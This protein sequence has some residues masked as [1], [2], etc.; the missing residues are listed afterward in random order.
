MVFI[1][2]SSSFYQTSLATH[3]PWE[4]V[5]L[6]RS[7]P[8]QCCFCLCLALQI[9]REKDLPGS[10]WDSFLRLACLVI[11]VRNHPYQSGLCPM[12]GRSCV[13][14]F[15]ENWTRSLAKDQMN[16]VKPKY[17]GRDARYSSKRFQRYSTWT[18]DTFL[19]QRP[20]SKPPV[21]ATWPG[22][23]AEV[24]AVGLAG[25]ECGHESHKAV[26]GSPCSLL[27]RSDD[28]MRK[29]M[30]DTLQLPDSFRLLF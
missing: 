2:G 6:V 8:Q 14:L 13:N 25:H 22:A 10:G 28:Q 23:A 24:L 11:I 16:Q 20:G 27:G 5:V 19:Y 9:L 30:D 18:N 4:F 3:L 15:S 29:T 21:A 7:G 17:K 1:Q 26:A 12:L